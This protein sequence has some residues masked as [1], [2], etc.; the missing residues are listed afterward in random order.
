MGQIVKFV[1]LVHDCILSK[2]QRNEM[3]RRYSDAIWSGLK[4]LTAPHRVANYILSKPQ[5]NEMN[6]QYCDGRLSGMMNALTV[7]R[8]I[9]VQSHEP[10]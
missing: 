5:R 7:Q 1:E 9:S 2:Q 8:F 4:A 3:N 6:R 10:R